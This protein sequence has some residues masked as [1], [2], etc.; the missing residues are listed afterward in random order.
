LLYLYWRWL[1]LLRNKKEYNINKK[2][3]WDLDSFYM[4]KRSYKVSY[5]NIDTGLKYTKGING[6]E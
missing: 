5:T 4:Y 3:A 1:K 6:I 2:V